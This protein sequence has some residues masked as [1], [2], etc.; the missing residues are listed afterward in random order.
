MDMSE[1]QMSEWNRIEK[2]IQWH[3]V[4]IHMLNMVHTNIDRV[5]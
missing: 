5:D 4:H 1:S 2:S 3:V